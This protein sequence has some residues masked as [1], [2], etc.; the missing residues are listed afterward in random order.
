M[1]INKISFF[2]LFAIRHSFF[3]TSGVVDFPIQ[4]I[5][6]PQHLNNKIKEEREAR[7]DTL[8]EMHWVY[9]LQNDISGKFYI[10]Y[11]EDLQ[12]RIAEHH[13]NKKGRWCNQQQGQWQ[14]AHKESFS[15]KREALIREKEIKRKK[16]RRYIEHL[17]QNTVCSSGS[18][19]SPV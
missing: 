12:R 10:G 2:L 1:K 16:S 18:S 14:L 5:G 3:V 7:L 15:N 4:S 13:C 9:I 11:T 17:I 6:I 19:I 8:F